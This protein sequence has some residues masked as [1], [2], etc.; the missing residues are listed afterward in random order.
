MSVG[1][2]SER[3]VKNIAPPGTITASTLSRGSVLSA[4]ERSGLSRPQTGAAAYE[5]YLRGRYFWERRGPTALLKSLDEYR[6]AIAELA[7]ET[8]VVSAPLVVT[9]KTVPELALPPS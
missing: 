8:S 2:I 4:R 7:K 6:A 1:P 5:H 9:L 3:W